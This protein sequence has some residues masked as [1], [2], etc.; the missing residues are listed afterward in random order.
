[1]KAIVLLSAVVAG[2]GECECCGCRAKWTDRTL[3]VENGLFV[4]EYAVIG[5]NPENGAN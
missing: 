2:T 4:R 3:R 1:M 5:R